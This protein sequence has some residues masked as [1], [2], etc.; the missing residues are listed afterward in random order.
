MGGHSVVRLKNNVDALLE[1]QVIAKRD[2]VVYI[3]VVVKVVFVRLRLSV[4]HAQRL[5]RGRR[6]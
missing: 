3:V 2:V 4:T 1:R 5:R 6:Q